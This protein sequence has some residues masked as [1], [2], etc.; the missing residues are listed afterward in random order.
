ML[1]YKAAIHN[2]LKKKEIP[3]QYNH[4]KIPISQKFSRKK[5]L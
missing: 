5:V 4:T 1:I 2:I 3:F